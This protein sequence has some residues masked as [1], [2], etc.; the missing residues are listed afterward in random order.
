MGIYKRMNQSCGTQSSLYA[1]VKEDGSKAIVQGARGT[2]VYDRVDSTEIKNDLWKSIKSNPDLTARDLIPYIDALGNYIFLTNKPRINGVVLEGDKSTADL[3]IFGQVNAE[4]IYFNDGSTLQEKFDSGEL[5]VSKYPDL[6]QKPSINNVVLDGE[7]TTVDL[8]IIDD[9]NTSALSTWSS[10][11]IQQKL[12]NIV[13]SK[14]I[15]GS[16]AEPIIASELDVGSYIISGF[17]QSSKTNNTTIRVPR[18]QYLVNKDV[19]NVTVFWDAN[20]YT[21][22]QY[23]IIFKHEGQDAPET[24]TLEMLTKEEVETLSLDCGEF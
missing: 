2:V 11:Q 4:G 13:V 20:P 5:G 16:D 15:T 6:Q 23:Y 3:Q 1:S 21:K 19:E 24:H 7:L 14:E 17:V 8:G 9:A 22:S 10:Q 18:K 12:N